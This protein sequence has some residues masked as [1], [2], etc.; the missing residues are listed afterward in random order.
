MI[1]EELRRQEQEQEQEE[2]NNDH[3]LPVLGEYKST[4]SLKDTVP[5]NKKKNGQGQEEGMMARRTITKK[6][7]EKTRT[8]TRARQEQEQEEKSND[9]S[10]PVLGE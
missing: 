5:H 9:H 1:K 3:S 2:K 8:R 6:T 10:L 7:T 4:T